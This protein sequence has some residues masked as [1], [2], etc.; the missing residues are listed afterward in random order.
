MTQKAG[1]GPPFSLREKDTT[2]RIMQEIGR[3]RKPEPRMI[4]IS[5]SLLYV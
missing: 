3:S 2:A 1:L 4:R 5:A